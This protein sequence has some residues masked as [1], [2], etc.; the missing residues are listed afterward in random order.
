MLDS[1]H[2]RKMLIVWLV[3]FVL[4]AAIFMGVL[5]GKGNYGLYGFEEACFYP[6][7]LLILS[8]LLVLVASWGAFDMF[9]YGFR[10][11]FSHMNPDPNHVDKYA[12]YTQ[13]V[14]EKRTQRQYSKPPLL[15]FF[16]V[17]GLFLLAAIIMMII[18]RKAV[19]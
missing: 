8:G 12:D 17:G 14:Q 2:Q 10:S 15:P 19:V 13:Y 11:V 6:G 4:A 7:I 5:F 9:V 3:A 16:V 18:M 1:E